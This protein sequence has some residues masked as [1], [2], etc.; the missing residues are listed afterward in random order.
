V[1]FIS[2]EK[3]KIKKVRF[4]SKTCYKNVLTN[5][6]PSIMGG[7]PYEI[8]KRTNAKK[9]ENDEPKDIETLKINERSSVNVF[10]YV[11]YEGIHSY[12]RKLKDYI[13]KNPYYYTLIKCK[14]P[15]GALYCENEK[16]Y[17]S[18]AIIPIKIIKGKAN[19][20]DIK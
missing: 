20:L 8:G 18:T 4:I 15:V 13:N 9:I 12:K 14:I 2:K 5:L 6:Q 16:E 17:V 1:C 3:P 19:V 10:G 11:I 7:P